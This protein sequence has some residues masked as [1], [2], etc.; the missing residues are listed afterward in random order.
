MFVGATS[1]IHPLLAGSRVF[2]IKE[3][4]VA[5]S[6]FVSCFVTCNRAKVVRRSF[7]IKNVGIE[8]EPFGKMISKIA[9]LFFDGALD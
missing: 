7:L 5:V 9:T 4:V 8:V 6:F 2:Y 3:R 1:N